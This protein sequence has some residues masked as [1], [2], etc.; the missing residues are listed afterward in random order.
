[1]EDLPNF[2]PE[3]TKAYFDAHDKWAA[4]NIP[5]SAAAVSGGRVSCILA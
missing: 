3:S 2:L 1:M 4:F 5:A